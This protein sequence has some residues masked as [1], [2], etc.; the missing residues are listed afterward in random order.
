[1]S[2]RRTGWWLAAAALAA[3]L[4]LVAAG[5]GGDDGEEQAA[6]ETGTEAGGGEGEPIRA[7]V[8]LASSANTYWQAALEGV[9]E[10]ADDAGGVEIQIFDGKFDTNL[11]KNQLRDALVSQ[12]F[13]V[14]FVGPNDGSALVPEIEEAVAQDIKVG[15]TLVPCGRDIRATEVQIDGVVAEASIPFYENGQHL[16]ELTAQACEGKDPCKVVWLPGLPSLPL[17]QAR[18]DGLES[19][20]QEHDSIE[21]V[22]TQGGGYLAEPALEAT[23]DI[24]QANPD[25][26]VIVSS[27]DQMIVGAE[28]AVRA[29]G[30]EGEVAL[31][32][33]GATVDGVQAIKE[34]RWFASA[35]YL[36]RTEAR[37][38]AELLF[39]AAR[40]EDITGRWI[41]PLKEAGGIDALIT[42]EN[43]DEFKPEFQG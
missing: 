8:F 29:A 33:N 38:V 26:S 19:V 20:L 25:T 31:I 41:D 39:R 40:G 2:T 27:G 7:A 5:C 13:N 17:E 21:I 16:G 18:T 30:K 22:S 9:R 24:L 14:W 10:A 6:D 1:M 23:Q 12:Q 34:G 11:Q 43:A 37:M 15:C 3:A 35:A 36:P 4:A 28:R 32:G 42:K